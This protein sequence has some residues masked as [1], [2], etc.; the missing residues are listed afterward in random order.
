MLP[1]KGNQMLTYGGAKIS[2]ILFLV[3]Q[4]K[5]LINF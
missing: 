2:R 5:E 1:M 4:L 3:K